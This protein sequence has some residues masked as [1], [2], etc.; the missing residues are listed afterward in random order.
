MIVCSE[1]SPDGTATLPLEGL[2]TFRNSGCTRPLAESRFFRPNQYSL[3]TL[4]SIPGARSIRVRGHGYVP[5]ASGP[6]DTVKHRYTEALRASWSLAVA[7][8]TRNNYRD[9]SCSS[10]QRVR[11]IQRALGLGFSLAELKTILAVRDQG[12]AP[13]RRVRRMLNAKIGDVR[14]RQ[15]HL[16]LLLSQLTRIAKVWDR[17]L[18]LAKQGQPALLLENVRLEISATHPRRNL[19]NKSKRGDWNPSTS[20][21]RLSTTSTMSS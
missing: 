6:S 5:W 16:T 12:G 11:L 9:Y 19:T 17:R 3:L 15:K 18:K 8:R 4:E 14:Q 10:P 2:L 1:V 13:C 7:T 21:R 20:K